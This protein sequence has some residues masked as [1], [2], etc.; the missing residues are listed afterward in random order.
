MA[1]QA[2]VEHLETGAPLASDDWP[3]SAPMTVDPPVSP[4]RMEG[5]G[6]K[7]SERMDTLNP[8][9]QTMVTVSYCNHNHSKR[10]S[11]GLSEG[12]NS[13]AAK[14]STHI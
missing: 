2:A 14:N 4:G 1:R 13:I 10:L 5:A 11:L 3:V 7:G 9:D 12:V 8:P 6:S